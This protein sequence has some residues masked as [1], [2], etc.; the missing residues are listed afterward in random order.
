MILFH[1]AND[2]FESK[3]IHPQPKVGMYF[4]L[5]YYPSNYLYFW[6]YREGKTP[7]RHSIHRHGQARLWL[8]LRP[9]TCMIANKVLSSLVFEIIRFVCSRPDILNPPRQ[10]SST[11]RR[12]NSQEISTWAEP[13]FCFHHRPHAT[14]HEIWLPILF[15]R[16]EKEILSYWRS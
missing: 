13:F 6:S 7:Y 9:R 11:F 10:S 4:A 12:G 5:L 3:S 1:I 15:T 8:T 16:Y 14:T 2:S